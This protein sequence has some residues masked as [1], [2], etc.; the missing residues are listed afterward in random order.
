MISAPDPCLTPLFSLPCRRSRPES[1]F[2]SK[3]GD[4]RGPAGKVCV[5]LRFKLAGRIQEEV[6]A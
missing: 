1:H 4:K 5:W 3:K 2:P 6:K